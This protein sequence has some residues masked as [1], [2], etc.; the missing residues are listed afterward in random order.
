[1]VTFK[2]KISGRKRAVR[3]IDKLVEW[4]NHVVYESFDKSKLPTMNTYREMLWKANY[5][6]F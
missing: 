6:E 1:M 4:E 3:E 5:R 2:K